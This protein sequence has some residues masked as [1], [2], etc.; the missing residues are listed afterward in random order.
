MLERR[1]WLR[2]L[3]KFA[4]T[5]NG[6]ID[7]EELV[8]FAAKLGW[9]TER[10][11]LP[12]VDFA[13]P[14]SDAAF[15]GE[16]AADLYGTLS[17]RAI[18]C[19]GVYWHLLE[20]A[21]RNSQGSNHVRQANGVL[22]CAPNSLGTIRSWMGQV[23]GTRIDGAKGWLR[24]FLAEATNLRDFTPTVRIID[25]NGR[26]QDV[27]VSWVAKQ[28]KLDLG[29]V[30]IGEEDG[31]AIIHVDS[32]DW[33]AL[34]REK[35]DVGRYSRLALLPCGGEPVPVYR[36][37]IESFQQA[38][39]RQCAFLPGRQRRGILAAGKLVA[40]TGIVP[41]VESEADERAY[42]VVL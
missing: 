28:T 30:V 41:Y 35:G 25:R 24:A 13:D 3:V 1:P 12:E 36:S 2:C 10:F 14:D 38:L 4:A 6:R 7:I 11:A 33:E 5:S 21:L 31:R 34:I 37:P 32:I 29:C 23:S 8:A 39:T 9:N 19:A 20:T 18:F 27:S 42:S 26:I 15:E 22:A 16:K 40:C 17:S